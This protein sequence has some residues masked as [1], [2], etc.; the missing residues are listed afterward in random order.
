LTGAGK[1]ERS[2]A[3]VAAQAIEEFVARQAWQLADIEAGLEEAE[4]GDFASQAEVDRIVA[5]YV[6]PAARS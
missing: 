3:H 1:M 5:K 6:K 4:A 2:P